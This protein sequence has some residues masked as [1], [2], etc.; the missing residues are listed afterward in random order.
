[1]DYGLCTTES[2]PTMGP[3]EEV[4]DWRPKTSLSLPELA[5]IT[6]LGGGGKIAL[7]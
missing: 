1:M 7:Y 6:R 4:K 5:G 3:C 2:T